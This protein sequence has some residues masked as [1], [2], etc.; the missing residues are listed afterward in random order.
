MTKSGE[1]SDNTSCF[2]KAKDD[3]IL[4]ILLARDPI[5]PFVIREEKV[6]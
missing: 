6:L 3:E 4:F 1:I 2:N 5:A